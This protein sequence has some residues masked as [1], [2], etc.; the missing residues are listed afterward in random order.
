MNSQAIAKARQP[1][2]ARIKPVARIVI[3]SG[4]HRHVFPLASTPA[5][6]R[7]IAAELSRALFPSPGSY[8]RANRRDARAGAKP[9]TGN[10]A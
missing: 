1:G 4:R 3:G 6:Q 5:D 8:H 9:S 10:P 2:R 7:R